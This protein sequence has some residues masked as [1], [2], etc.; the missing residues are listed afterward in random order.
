MFFHICYSIST[1]PVLAHTTRVL[2]QGRSSPTST[3]RWTVE[4]YAAMSPCVCLRQPLSTEL[5]LYTAFRLYSDNGQPKLYVTHSH[6]LTSAE[7]L[8]PHHLWSA[9]TSARCVDGGIASNIACPSA[10]YGADAILPPHPAHRDKGLLFTYKSSLILLSW[11]M[12]PVAKWPRS[13][14]PKE[15]SRECSGQ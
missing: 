3:T 10:K 13:D 8:Q 15:A 6:C 2:W 12:V 14:H 5:T 7:L 9:N 4:A 11:R 1:T